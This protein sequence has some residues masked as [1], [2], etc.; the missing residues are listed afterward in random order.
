[1]VVSDTLYFLTIRN[2]TSRRQ[3]YSP[4]SLTPMFLKTRGPRESRGLFRSGFRTVWSNAPSLYH[5]T[6]FISEIGPMPSVTLHT[7]VMLSPCCNMLLLVTVTLGISSSEKW[8]KMRTVV[9]RFWRYFYHEGWMWRV[10][11]VAAV[12]AAVFVVPQFHIF[13]E[14]RGLNYPNTLQPYCYWKIEVTLQTKQDGRDAKITNCK[15]DVD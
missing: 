5:E 10:E 12:V 4:P 14:K 15:K 2:S 7:I 9:S 13:S 8:H 11:R 3:T 1:M 6:L